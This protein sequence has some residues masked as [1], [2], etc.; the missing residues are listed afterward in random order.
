SAPQKNR[1]IPEN[2]KEIIRDLYDLGVK[3]VLNII[4]ALRDKKLD[5]IPTQRQIYN[6]LNELKKDKF[7]DAG[8][9]YLEFEKWSKNNM[10]NE[11][12][13]EHDGFVLDYYVSLT[14]KYF[15]ISLSTNYLINLADKRDILV[16]DATYK[17]LL[18]DAAEAMTNAF[19]K[20]FGSNFTRIMCWAHAER[21]MTKKLLFIKNPRVRENITQDLYALQSSY[22]QPKFNIG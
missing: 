18:A 19:E 5:K 11:F 3:S 10:K 22:S 12:L 4:Y 14:E 16:V 17:F 6:F 21:A 13:G 20:V 1:G 2:T 9:T 7:G 15:R 8:M